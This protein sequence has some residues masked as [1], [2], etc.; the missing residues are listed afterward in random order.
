MKRYLMNAVS[1]RF[2]EE[3]NDFLDPHKRKKKY[4]IPFLIK[5]TVK[6]LIEGEGVP[7][8][9]VDL[10]LVNG[11][12]VDFEYH[13]RDG[14]QISVYPEFELIDI[15]PLNRL[16]P[17]PL[18]QT[19]FIVDA[20][21]GRLS[22]YLRMLGFDTLFDMNLH[23]PDIIK[24][25]AKEKR[26]ILTR[27][28]GILKNSRVVRGYFIRNQEPDRQLREVVRKF[29][30]KGQFR[31]FTRCIA[32]NGNILPI[33]KDRIGKRAP[34][35]VLQNFDKFYACSECERVYWEGSHHQ[36]MLEKIQRLTRDPSVKDEDFM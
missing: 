13:I 1:I 34:A 29:H 36:R 14:D 10:I 24:I 22:R 8:V 30:L 7:H 11:N 9:E 33:S 6:D 15:S 21:L 26:I 17:I 28:L 19:K 31:P 5:R 12:P 2:Y 25:A 18:R 20:N 35:Q 3:L 4:E 27:D 32:C 16:R 23:D